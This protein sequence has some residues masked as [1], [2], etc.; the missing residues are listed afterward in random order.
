MAVAVA[1]EGS[2][3]DNDDDDDDD[4]DGEEGGGGGVS[5][6]VGGDERFCAA[7]DT[8]GDEGNSDGGAESDV[9]VIGLPFSLPFDMVNLDENKLLQENKPAAGQ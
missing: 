6:K 7:D 3:D 1:V 9:N 8:K 4:D 5:G 2:D